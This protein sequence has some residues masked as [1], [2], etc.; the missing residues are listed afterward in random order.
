MAAL[1]P[2]TLDQLATQ[3]GNEELRLVTRAFRDDLA[4]L[5]AQFAA[6]PPGQA[7]RHAAHALAGAAANCGATP[8]AEAAREAMNGA[9]DPAL[10]QSLL[11]ETLAALD[12]RLA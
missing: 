3:I 6:L 8:L 10:L 2:T 5:G 9:G 1:D 4:S 12:A 11:A 7:R